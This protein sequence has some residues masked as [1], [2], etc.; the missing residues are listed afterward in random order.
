MENCDCT[1]RWIWWGGDKELCYVSDRHD[2]H[3]D[4]D[5]DDDGNGHGDGD[6]DMD[7]DDGGPHLRFLPVL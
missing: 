5:D 2:D 4:V 3:G 7:D 1:V 6:G